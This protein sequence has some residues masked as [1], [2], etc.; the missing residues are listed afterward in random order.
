MDFGLRQADLEE[1]DHIL[2]QF[3][4]IEEAFLF[5]SRAK[6]TFKSGSDVDIAIKGESVDHDVVAKLLFQLNEESALPY[7][8][9]VI[10]YEEISEKALLEHV[11]RV[12]RPIYIRE[13]H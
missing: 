5:G 8:F 13:R 3:P 9:D 2:K 6:G 1:I 10:H 11:D 12:G 7:F 4:A